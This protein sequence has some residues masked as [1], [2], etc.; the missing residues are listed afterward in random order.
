[1]DSIKREKINLGG[2]AVLA[3]NLL[4]DDAEAEDGSASVEEVEEKEEVEEFSPEEAE[5]VRPPA[6]L[7]EHEVTDDSARMYLQ[8]IGRVSLLKAHE[9]KS[10]SQKIELG[11]CLERI[12]DSH[13]RKYKKFPSPAEMVI[14]L[15][16]QLS[17][18]YPVVQ[19]VAAHVVADSS[20]DM[21]ETIKDPKFRSA[22]DDVIDP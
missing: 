16:S 2:D 10:L 1:M 3:A 21:V 20:S 11:R 4:S 5:E 22:I 7:E 18:A 8:E 14:H 12:E 6:P 17:R 9:E 13:F 19:V 15:I